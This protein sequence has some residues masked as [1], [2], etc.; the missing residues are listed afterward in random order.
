MGKEVQVYRAESK[1]S[2]LLFYPAFQWRT[3]RTTVLL[4][5]LMRR[6]QAS[7]CFGRTARDEPRCTTSWLRTG[8]RW[9]P[10]WWRPSH[11]LVMKDTHSVR[12]MSQETSLLQIRNPSYIMHSSTFYSRLT[13]CL[14]PP[15][16]WGNEAEA[17][18]HLHPCGQSGRLCSH[19]RQ[20]NHCQHAVSTQAGAWLWQHCHQSAAGRAVWLPGC[21]ECEI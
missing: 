13:F 5:L 4:H 3:L 11:R 12:L 20:E 7:L 6:I 9:W 8:T 10:T 18:A 1:L 21:C 16:L 17:S 15:G 14:S 2:S 19:G